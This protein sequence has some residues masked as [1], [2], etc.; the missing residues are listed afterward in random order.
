MD[1][2]ETF[3]WRHKIITV[4]IVLVL[5][6]VLL[7]G[8]RMRGP[9][10]SYRVDFVNTGNGAP[11][12]LEVGVA[13]R[14]ITPDLDKYD[15]YDDTNNN[16][17]YEPKQG[18]KYNDRN[19]NGKFDPVWV[20]GFNSSR[21]A[22]GV[23]DPLWARAIA[24]RNDGVTLVMVTLDSIGIFH[25]KFIAVRKSLDPALKIDHVIFSSLH[26][27]E[28]PDT[29]GIWSG[30]IPWPSAF[31]HA[32]MRFVQDACKDAI[33]EAVRNLQPADMTCAVVEPANISDFVDDSRKPIVIDKKINCIQ[34]NKQGTT[35]P[36]ATL[37]N[38]GNH[39]E[40]LGG[41]NPL[42][43]SDFSHYWRKGVE[44]GVGEP[45]GVSGIGGMCLYF[46]GMVGGLMTQLHTTVPHRDGVRKFREDTW[47]KAEALG[48]NLALL[49]VNALR[50]PTAWKVEKPQLAVAA[51]TIYVPMGNPLFKWAMTFGLIHPGIY[52]GFKSRSEVDAVRLGEVEMLTVPGELYPEIADGGIE[53]PAG[54]DFPIAPVEVP[55]LRRDVMQGK[56]RM[57]IG[58]ANDEIGY[59]IPKS[60]WDTKEPRAYEPKGQYGEDN[61]GGPDVAPTIHRE[62]KALLE[63]LHAALGQPA[64]Q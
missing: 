59:I 23:H 53:A 21:P 3:F 30:P 63:R 16:N 60:Q 2:R 40:A 24:F 37:V 1:L 17:R 26:D 29:M 7:L 10:R 56:M 44:D 36:I 54:Q 51:K 52:W 12:A 5:L 33:E 43:T 58:L 38:W 48:D 4:L 22:K 13:K 18:E 8:L 62:G 9:Y 6:V 64:A 31:D 15:T 46:Q 55:P 49:T 45:N 11:S 25:E 42:L 27:H 39:P 61:S 20:A 35:L 28:A 34:F 19:K 14:D 57:I 47:E 41:G 32:Y 50:G